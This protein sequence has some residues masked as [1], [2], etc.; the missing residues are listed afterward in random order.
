MQQRLL[1][2]E[3]VLTGYDALASLYPHIPSLSSFRAWEYA[4]FQGYA[5]TEPVLDLGCGDG[6]MFRLLWPTITRAVGVDLD[7]AMVDRA[8]YLGVYQEVHLAAAD[9]LPLA[10][11]SFASVFS[12]SAIE[13]MDD[14]E[15]VLA[16]VYR[17]LAPHGTFLFSAVTDKFVEWLL[18]PS[19]VGFCAPGAD[20]AQL[21]AQYL[22]YHNLVNPLPVEAWRTSLERA[23]FEVLE[24]VPFVPEMFGRMFLLIDELWHV[25]CGEGELGG[26]MHR[27]LAERPDFPIGFRHVLQ[28]LMQMELHWDIGAGTVFLARKRS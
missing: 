23:G 24:H 21:R 13:H 2:P 11:G 22:Q 7:P 25:P 12:N 6:Q 3:Q 28:G 14:L 4:A 1:T 18:L 20:T 10:E 26:A 5:L 9:E 15:G 19:I 27:Y 17:C 16:N 8:I